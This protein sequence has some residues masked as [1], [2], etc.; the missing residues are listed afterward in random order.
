MGVALNAEYIDIF[1]DVDGI[2]TADPRIVENAKTLST[3][4]YNESCNLAQQGAKVI[5]PRAVEIAMQKNIPIRIKSTFT[6][7][8]GTLITN[9][10]N[11]HQTVEISGQR[12]VTGIT[13]MP[14]IAQ[15]KVLTEQV[16]EQKKINLNIFK[17]LP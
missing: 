13:H 6:D 10:G 4:T 3:I 15:I 11:N 5:H 17:V 16:E 12:L 2:K 9:N 1:T 7:S 8:P 14:N